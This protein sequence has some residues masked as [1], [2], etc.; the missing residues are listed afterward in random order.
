MNTLHVVLLVSWVYALARVASGVLCGTGG[1]SV[2]VS[3]LSTS[4]AVLM[5]LAVVQDTDSIGVPLSIHTKYNHSY[6]RG[7]TYKHAY[8]SY[9]YSV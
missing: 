1:D 5:L 8:T 7:C 4:V 9:R 3:L 2:E 6:A